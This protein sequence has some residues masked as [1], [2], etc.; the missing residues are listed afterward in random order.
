MI[1]FCKKKHYMS[2]TS[3]LQSAD[4]QSQLVPDFLSA[5]VAQL[6]V[7]SGEEVD[8]FYEFGMKLITHYVDKGFPP[9]N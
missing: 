5:L 1:K 2:S 4:L 9:F 3:T 6:K 7:A 8:W